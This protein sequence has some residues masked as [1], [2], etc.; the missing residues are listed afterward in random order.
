LLQVH[1]KKFNMTKL[2]LTTVRPFGIADI[3]LASV[4]G[5]A[6]QPDVIEKILTDKVFAL[7]TKGA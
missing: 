7:C 1:A 6:D 5:I 2:P 4:P 3:E